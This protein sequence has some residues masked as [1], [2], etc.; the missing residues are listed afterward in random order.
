MDGAI[1]AGERAGTA[2]ANAVRRISAAGTET[3]VDIDAAPT[4]PGT[5]SAGGAVS[6]GGGVSVAAAAARA[7]ASVDES[8]KHHQPLLLV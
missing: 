2:A 8:P 6:G 1:R 5:N 7:S 4:Q 3:A